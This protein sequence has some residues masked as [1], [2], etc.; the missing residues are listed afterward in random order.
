MASADLSSGLAHRIERVSSKLYPWD[1]RVKYRQVLPFDSSNKATDLG[2]YNILDSSGE[3]FILI[4]PPFGMLFSPGNPD[5]PD[6]EG[7]L[8]EAKGLVVEEEAIQIEVLRSKLEREAF[9]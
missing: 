9:I 2:N 7:G 8:T 3:H 5:R 6:T 4:P 1:S